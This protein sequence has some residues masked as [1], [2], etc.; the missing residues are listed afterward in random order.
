MPGMDGIAVL[1]TIRSYLRWSRV[2]VA[3]FTAYPED[4]RL[5]HVDQR[6]VSRIFAKSK[7]HLDDLLEWVNEQAGRAVPP[8]D[9]PPPS[10]Q[11]GV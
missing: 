5:W 6:G 8:P 1:Q 11:A 10:T 4:P 9:M 7:F 2:P 3:M